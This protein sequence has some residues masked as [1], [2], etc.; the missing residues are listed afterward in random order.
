MSGLHLTGQNRE[1]IKPASEARFLV[2]AQPLATV[3]P[4]DNRQPPSEPRRCACVAAA[5]RNF[6]VFDSLA[7]PELLNKSVLQGLAV[8]TNLNRPPE[9]RVR[10]ARRD[11]TGPAVNHKS[12]DI[13]TSSADTH[14][15][16][17]NQPYKCANESTH[18][19]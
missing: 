18:L 3:R 13:D 16:A 9:G 4:T 11:V 12:R 10:H 8:I 1:P 2:G 17:C 6:P 14:R 19:A 15:S 7:P 5:T